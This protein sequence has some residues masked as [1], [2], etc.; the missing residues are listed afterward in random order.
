MAKIIPEETSLFNNILNS[1]LDELINENEQEVDVI[2]FVESPHYLNQ[3]LHGVEKFILKVFYGLPLD[4]TTPYIHIRYFPYDEKGKMMTEVEYALFLLEQKR[5]NITDLNFESSQH[6]LLV[7]GRRGGKCILLNSYIFCKIGMVKI[8]DLARN[9][10]IDQT[11]ELIL[12][13]VQEKGKVTNSDL[14]YNGGI[15]KVKNIKTKF[16]YEIGATLNHR[17]KVMLPTG[18]ID[19]KYMEDIAVGDMVCINRKNDIWPDEPYSINFDCDESKFHEKIKS[20]PPNELDEKTAIL[21]GL[22]VGDGTW[23]HEGTL[24][25]T[26]GWHQENDLIQYVEQLFDDV[27]GYHC[28]QVRKNNNVSIQ[29]HSKEYRRFFDY[30]GY[31]IKP[32]KHTKE[33]PWIILKERKNI[34]AKFLSGLYE[35]DGCV[36]EKRKITF[37]SDSKEMVNQTQL[38]LLNF[39]IISSRKVKHNKKYDRDYY[40]L[41]I[42]GYRNLKIFR[43][44]I[45]FIS[46]Y[47]KDR[48]NVYFDKIT[49]G[50]N[51]NDNQDKIPFQQKRMQEFWKENPTNRKNRGLIR[52]VAYGNY[53]LSYSKLDKIFIEFNV[54]KDHYFQYIKDCDYFFDEVVVH[55]ISEEQVYD[56]HIPDGNM[57]TSNGFMSHNTFIASMICCYETYKLISKGNPQVHYNLIKGQKIKIITV[58][59]NSDQAK[60]ASDMIKNSIFQS[61]WLAKYCISHKMTTIRMQTKYEYDNKLPPSVI[62]EAMPCT[63]SGL[64]GHTVIVAIL[65]EL[66]HFTDSGSRSGDQVYYSLTP[67]IATFGRDGK[68]LA[69]SNPYTKSGIFYTQYIKAMGN[70]IEEPL[71][72]IRAFKLPSWEMNDTLSFEF[73]KNEYLLNP[74]SFDYEYGAEFSGVITG[75]FKFPEKID[76]CINFSL[77]DKVRPASQKTI[78]WVAMDPASVGNGYALCMVHVEDRKTELGTKKVVVVDRWLRWLATDDEF[79]ELG[80]NMIDPAVIDEYII[81]LSQ[82][83]KISKVRYDQY[84]SAAS[85]SKLVKRGLVAERVPIT[86]S[87]NMAIYKN[88]RNL[89]Y[90]EE[91][92]LMDNP[93]G[94]MELKYLQEKK[95]NFGRF[96]VA[97]P[98][99]GE[100]TTDDMADVLAVAAFMAI[101]ADVINKTTSMLGTKNTGSMV[102]S[103]GK[104]SVPTSMRKYQKQ[105]MMQS[106]RSKL[107]QGYRSGGMR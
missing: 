94:I 63:S 46:N 9:E 99:T 78:H 48:L 13:V 32:E 55:N 95:T 7:C 45:G 73:F 23:T 28:T 31:T 43:D 16:G 61:P 87:I 66:A 98:V 74:E 96:S 37:S 14:F 5:I 4:D 10:A 90:N 56:L 79:Q 75:F 62:I 51:G 2:T 72:H 68:I 18:Y 1:Q 81:E 21:L 100:V 6:L 44:E 89:I 35:A 42:S 85:V 30:I 38:L 107:T 105:Q 15:K 19:W 64:R 60:I 17:I 41:T 40:Y 29:I 36:E 102:L 26:V 24:Q 8:G 97:A 91:I 88:L 83:F 80:L 49:H 12:D 67:S 82:H 59:S 39:G 70:G 27:I 104:G 22:L 47:N 58:A 101:E 53:D 50:Y 86:S 103:I 92:E 34:V 11:S 106:M 69:L 84:E 77:I 71:Q 33:I 57:Y 54:D 25:L 20:S 76:D 52:H 93:M 65:D 3:P